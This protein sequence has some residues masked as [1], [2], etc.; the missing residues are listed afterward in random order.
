M[1]DTRLVAAAMEKKELQGGIM[2]L[3]DPMSSYLDV[4]SFNQYVGWHDGLPEKC[5]RVCWEFS[6]D[7]PVFISEFGGGALQGNHGPENQ[8]WTEEFQADL[9]RHSVKMLENMDGL[10]GCTP[11]ILT[12]FRS[13]RRVLTDIQDG[14]NRKGLISDRGIRKQAFYIMQEWYG[15]LK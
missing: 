10:S 15:S 13:P 9:Y 8:R 5:D 6:E 14:Y 12:D 11:W 1:D 2:T 7:K 3:D 4:L